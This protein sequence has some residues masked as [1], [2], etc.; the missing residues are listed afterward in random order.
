MLG[1]AFVRAAEDRLGGPLVC[2]QRRKRDSPTSSASVQHLTAVYGLRTMEPRW[3]RVTL[4][5]PNESFQRGPQVRSHW[6]SEQCRLPLTHDTKSKFGN[7]NFFVWRERR[8]F[9]L[10]ETRRRSSNLVALV[11]DNLFSFEVTTKLGDDLTRML[12]R[13]LDTTTSESGPFECIAIHSNHRRISYAILF[14]EL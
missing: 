12:L 9:R 10:F 8:C 14:G 5:Q 13:R 3:Y 7:F 2:P 1:T 11:R 4:R 6:R